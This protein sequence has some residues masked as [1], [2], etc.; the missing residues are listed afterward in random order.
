M[1]IGVRTGFGESK[2][3]YGGNADKPF[4]GFRQGNGASPSLW[5]L[6][7]IFLFK[8]MEL[9]GLSSEQ[10]LAISG[11]TI[12]FIGF[13]YVDDTDLVTFSNSVEESKDEL[14]ER[15]NISTKRWQECLDV[16]GGTLRPSKCYW[17]LLWYSWKNGKWKLSQDIPETPILLPD[18]DIEVPVDYLKLDIAKEVVGVWVSPSGSHKKQLEITLGKISIA[19]RK[20]NTH[21][22]ESNL[23]WKGFRNSLWKSL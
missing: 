4:S 23:M 13:A 3:F 11:E 7:S 1:K 10:I 18:K 6:T 8:V 19:V 17:Y 15:L 16:T 12:R 22:I 21:H 9:M 2:G 20:F 5:I 14:I